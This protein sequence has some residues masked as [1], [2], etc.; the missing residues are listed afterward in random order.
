VRSTTDCTDWV[1]KAWVCCQHG[2]PSAALSDAG[3]ARQADGSFARPWPQRRCVIQCCRQPV[4]VYNYPK[5]IKAF[6]MRLNDD[7]KTV[8]AMDVLV[9]KVGELIGGSQREDR[10][11][12]GLE[13][14]SGL[15]I[16]S[17]MSCFVTC[18]GP[19]WRPAA[20]GEVRICFR[21]VKPHHHSANSSRG[22]AWG[23]V[24]WALCGRQ[25]CAVLQGHDC[26]NLQQQ[27]M[28]TTA[29]LA[30]AAHTCVWPGLLLRL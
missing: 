27:S 7:G 21:A 4:I 13:S 5:D 12:V 9:P 25:W 18:R 19:Y 3:P 6:Y 14:A 26:S 10:L 24:V 23:F 8:A 20:G 17:T 30:A 15:K 22:C 2:T 1:L 11:E 16:L 28:C 29:N